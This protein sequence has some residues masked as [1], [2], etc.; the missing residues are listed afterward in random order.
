MKSLLLIALFGTG[1]CVQAQQP[2]SAKT[3]T[4]QELDSLQHAPTQRF[5]KAYR[6]FIRAQV[7]EKT[8]FKLGAVPELGYAGYVGAVYGLQA[9]LGVEQ[10]LV[11]A[12]SVLASL[13]TRYRHVGN[14]FDEVTL[15]GTLA[16]RWYY[17]QN[18]RMRTGK[19]ANNFSNQYLTLQGSQYLL[20]R[21]QMKQTGEV[22]SLDADNWVGIGF[23][24]QRRLGRFGYIDWTI[25]PAYAVNRPHRFAVSA[26]IYIGLGL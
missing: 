21:K 10:K 2:D 9:E 7:E 23:G 3:E 17:A 20:S 5:V 15:R 25:G 18:R 13:R 12:L 22:Q 19:S 8:L 24:V 14:Q 11:P 1:L 26:S 4:S 16:G 6:K